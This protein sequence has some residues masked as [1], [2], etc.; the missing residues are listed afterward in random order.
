KSSSQPTPATVVSLSN[1]SMLN[2][3]VVLPPINETA[4]KPAPGVIGSEAGKEIAKQGAGKGAG[5]KTG[6]GPSSSKNVQGSHPEPG[7]G[8]GR[9]SGSGSLTV[10]HITIPPQGHFGAV[11][12]GNSVAGEFP[13]VADAWNGRVAYTVY[14]H[15]GLNK[16]WIMQYALPRMAEA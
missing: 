6:E 9:V 1:L 2:G 12:V 15:V 10:A 11:V 13:E 8:S 16:S 7:E 4:S 3:T 5:P 14:L